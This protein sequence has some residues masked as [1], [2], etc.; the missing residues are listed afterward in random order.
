MIEFKLSEWK[1]S[2]QDQFASSKHT[3]H[4]VGLVELMV[5]V[6]LA[7]FLLLGLFSI[8]NTTRI[9]Y[10]AQTGLTQ[11][12]EKQRNAVSL[13]KGVIQL[14]GY[15]PAPATQLL[16]SD[17][18]EIKNSVFP[19]GT[20]GIYTLGGSIFGTYGGAGNNDTLRIRFQTGP[21][22]TAP[23]PNCQG[24][25]N[26]TG[27]NTVYDNLFSVVNNSNDG[28]SYLACAVG[29]N[30]GAVG[31]N[32]YLIDGVSSL[33]VLYGVDA[34]GQG[35]VTQYVNASYFTGAAQLK[36]SQVHSIKIII[37]Y[38]NPNAATAGQPATVTTT[39]T[40]QVMGNQ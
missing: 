17:P 24:N 27:T 30:G 32:Q 20:N 31:A 19:A 37:G 25:I 29:V 13:M 16:S 11:L 28:K 34:Q 33:Q 9:T 35:S 23:I 4:G 21:N 12:Q 38:A 5:G 22:D 6:A 18:S 40:I 1:L 3:Q 2:N 39:Q 10:S 14:A 26:N 8:F 36:W 7:L 15:F